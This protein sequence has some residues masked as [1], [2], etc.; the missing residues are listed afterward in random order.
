MALFEAAKEAC[1]L[2]SV[3]TDI[4]LT[5]NE[6]IVIY[7]D[8]NGCISIANNPTDHKRS[9]HIDIKYHFTREKIQKKVITV[10]YLSTG[11]Q[12]AD[13]LTKPLPA[14]KFRLIRDEVGL[15]NSEKE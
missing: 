7:E 3:L 1:W 13:I 11:E 9:K 14:V 8:N 2:K 15:R 12:L 10:K 5:L 4:K 6:P